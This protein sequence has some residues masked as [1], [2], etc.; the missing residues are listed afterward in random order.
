MNWTLLFKNVDIEKTVYKYYAYSCLQ[1]SY[2]LKMEDNLQILNNLFC[3]YFGRVGSLS[4]GSNP[5]CG[6]ESAKA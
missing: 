2:I 4:G 1:I 3:F 5:G 6:G